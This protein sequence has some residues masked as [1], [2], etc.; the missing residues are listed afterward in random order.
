[1][2]DEGAI[3]PLRFRQT[4]ERPRALG[5]ILRSPHFAERLSCRVTLHASTRLDNAFRP[6]L[7]HNPKFA[8]V[9]ET[10]LQR[11]LDLVLYAG[12]VSG[13]DEAACCV[14]I[15]RGSRL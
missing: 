15:D 10:V 3:L 5:H 9:G 1:M 11:L 4:G 6:V 7:A 2:L 8:E 12:A 13:V 14:E